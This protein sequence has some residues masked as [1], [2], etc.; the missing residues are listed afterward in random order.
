MN[1]LTPE[2]KWTGPLKPIG[3]DGG[4]DR[5]GWTRLLG[6]IT[7]GGVDHHVEAIE[8]CWRKDGKVVDPNVEGN[9]DAELEPVLDESECCWSAVREAGPDISAEQ[10][11]TIRGREYVFLITPYEA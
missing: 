2:L 5:D 1:D 7:I 4:T 8:V 9:E 11:V 3:D 10:T 6:T